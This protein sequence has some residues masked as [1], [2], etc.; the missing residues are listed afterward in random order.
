MRGAPR[1]EGCLNAGCGACGWLSGRRG[2]VR[3]CT[4]TRARRVRRA[5]STG[6]KVRIVVSEPKKATGVEHVVGAPASILKKVRPPAERIVS[7]VSSDSDSDGSE[8]S[9]VAREKALAAARTY[10]RRSEEHKAEMA[11]AAVAANSTFAEALKEEEEQEAQRKAAKK[12]RK[13]AAA[14]RLADEEAERERIQE[15]ADTLFSMA[16]STGAQHSHPSS[17]PLTTG[18]FIPGVRVS[19]RIEGFAGNAGVPRSDRV[20]IGVVRGHPAPLGVREQRAGGCGVVSP[21][22]ARGH[23]S[24]RRPR[25]ERVFE[26]GVE[27][28]RAHH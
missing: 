10:E 11:R 16:V 5:M 2:A 18:L 1:R 13:L 17:N 15:L 20:E 3:V 12:A 28:A 22:L 7:D 6:K 9:G 19:P 23:Y 14:E 8:D 24:R 26:S 27:R 25:P 21:T 4:A